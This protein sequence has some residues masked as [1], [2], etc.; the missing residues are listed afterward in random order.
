M[1]NPASGRA[2]SHSDWRVF[3]GQFQKYLLSLIGCHLEGINYLQI[4]LEILNQLKSLKSG[5][6][7]AL[8]LNEIA[9]TVAPRRQPVRG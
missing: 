7:I 5:H 2:P 9:A 1:D 6:A 4:W 3:L 8:F